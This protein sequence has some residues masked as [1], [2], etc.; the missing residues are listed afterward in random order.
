MTLRGMRIN[1]HMPLSLFPSCTEY[2][3][4]LCVRVFAVQLTPAGDSD[5]FNLGSH[6]WIFVA[7]AQTLL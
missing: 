1:L 2:S 3:A 5:G 6:S 4:M 7:Q